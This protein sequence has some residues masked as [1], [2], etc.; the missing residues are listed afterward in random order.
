LRRGVPHP[1]PAGV[2]GL[3]YGF[4]PFEIGHSYGHLNLT[5]AVLPPLLLLLGDELLVRQR[6]PAWRVGAL[7]GAAVG[8]QLLVGQELVGLSAVGAGAGVAVLGALWPAELRRRWRYVA[9]GL[10]AAAA[11]VLVADGLPL[12]YQLLG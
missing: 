2:G 11:V 10:A 4:S 9:V 6:R 3:I 12:A 7:I 8:A 5:L 1:V